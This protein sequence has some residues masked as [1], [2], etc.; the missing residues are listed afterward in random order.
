MVTVRLFISISPSP[1]NRPRFRGNQLP[2]RTKT[3]GQFFIIF[4]QL[5]MDSTRS[6]LAIFFC[7]PNEVRDKAHAN[8]GERQ[9]VDQTDQV[10][11]SVRE[12]L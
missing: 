8:R 7:Q 3:D 9:L 2:N 10:P 4:G 11:E 12:K 5:K 1:C 6:P